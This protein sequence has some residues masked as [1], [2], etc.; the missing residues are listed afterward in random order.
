MDNI[1]VTQPFTARHVWF[2]K[3]LG[4]GSLGRKLPRFTLMLCIALYL[5]NSDII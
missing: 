1:F 5:L 4:F 3:K 2:T